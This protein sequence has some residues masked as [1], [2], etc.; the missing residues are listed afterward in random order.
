MYDWVETLPEK[1]F[2]GIV[3]SAL[4]DYEQQLWWGTSR[5]KEVE[6]YFKTSTNQAQIVALIFLNGGKTS[7][8]NEK[9]FQKI[10]AGMKSEI[11]KDSE[12]KKL[13]GNQLISQFNPSEDLAIYDALQ[14]YAEG[15]SHKQGS[16]TTSALVH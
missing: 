6:G 14:T 4:H 1:Q 15:P 2:K 5:R 7:T 3:N 11:D 13:A 12:K 10:L 16:S 8:L 9:L